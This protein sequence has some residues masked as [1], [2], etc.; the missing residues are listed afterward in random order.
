MAPANVFSHSIQHHPVTGFPSFFVHPCLLGD[1]M[2]RFDCSK[3]NYL[4]MWLGL[5]G[6][7]V[8]LWVPKEMMMDQVVR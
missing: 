4:T 2:S 7:C 6:G 1:A 8:G 3:D 5:V